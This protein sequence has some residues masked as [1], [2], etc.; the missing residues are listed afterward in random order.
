M[1]GSPNAA[2]ELSPEEG[3]KLL[4]KMQHDIS[5][6][7][8]KKIGDFTLLE[9]GSRAMP[10]CPQIMDQRA[11]KY[12]KSAMEVLYQSNT[13]KQLGISV[14]FVEPDTADGIDKIKKFYFDGFT[15]IKLGH[16]KLL[17]IKPLDGKYSAIIITAVVIYSEKDPRID[18]VN[19]FEEPNAVFDYFKTKY[20]AT[21][22]A[23]AIA[24]HTGTSHN[25]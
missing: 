13:N 16:G 1:A 3:E 9:T 20:A 14:A 25:R 17:A 22:K 15:K 4:A 11:A 6:R 21:V 23:W 10:A 18:D 2:P 5:A 12:C 24:L 8:P 7:F 19:I